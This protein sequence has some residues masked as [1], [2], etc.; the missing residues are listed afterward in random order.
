MADFLNRTKAA[1][2]SKG[3]GFI[4][5]ALGGI[6]DPRARNALGGLADTVFPGLAGSTP[7]YRDNAYATLI[8]N[9]LLQNQ[10]EL[11]TS[12][13]KG[14]EG[15][16]AA[17][18]LQESYDWR[19]RLRPKQGGAEKFYSKLGQERFIMEPLEQTGGLVWFNTP[20]ITLSSIVIYNDAKP[21]GSNYPINTFVNSNPSDIPVIADF[22]ASDVYEAR[23]LLAVMVFLRVATKAYY[24][25]SAVASGDYGTPPP[26]LLFEYL[27]DH[28]FNKVPVIVSNYTIDFPSDVDYVPVV[29]NGTT[30]YVPTK[31]N[32]TVSLKPTHT[33]HKLRR[34]F[35]LDDIAN[36]RSYK[37]GYI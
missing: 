14:F 20:S 36:G 6:S 23:Y 19:A 27:G 22:T 10:T 12:V 24:G 37:Q 21:Q 34:T 3:N 8:Q 1:L 31:T 7:D 28:G 16:D 32:I 35:S 4:A 11:R 17:S 26:V 25:D 15:N 18:N 9:R 13:A 33:P 29:Y 5:D 2:G 30:T